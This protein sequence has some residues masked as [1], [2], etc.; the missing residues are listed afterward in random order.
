MYMVQDPHRHS[1]VQGILGI[2][3]NEIQG[4]QSDSNMVQGLSLDDT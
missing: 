2:T 1:V 3:Y 4:L